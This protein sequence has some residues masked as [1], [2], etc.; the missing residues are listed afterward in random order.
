VGQD[1]TETGA[2]GPR[3]Q[4]V[5]KAGS[6]QPA[7]KAYND[8]VFQFKSGNP[9]ERAGGWMKTVHEQLIAASEDDES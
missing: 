2:K 5:E 3:D 4:G 1:L 8:A 7:R 6:E 9:G